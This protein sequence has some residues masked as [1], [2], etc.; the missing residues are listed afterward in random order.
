MEPST[1]EEVYKHPTLEADHIAEDLVI[2]R[3]HS[4]YG[5]T[6]VRV[7]EDRF[8]I[9]HIEYLRGI[10]QPTWE[11]GVTFTKNL[12]SLHTPEPEEITEFIDAVLEQHLQPA[13][14]SE[15]MIESL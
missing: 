4:S 1:F 2:F 9:S 6:V 5:V 8:V 14:L 13:V 10:E 15:L 11:V 12:D 3:T 7:A